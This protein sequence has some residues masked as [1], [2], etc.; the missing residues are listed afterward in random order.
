MQL[1]IK[2][3]YWLYPGGL[4][5]SRSFGDTSAKLKEFQGNPK[6]LIAEPEISIYYPSKDTDFYLIACDGVF[7]VSTS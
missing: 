5:V 7:D 6:V 1:N 4:S 3:P 2:I